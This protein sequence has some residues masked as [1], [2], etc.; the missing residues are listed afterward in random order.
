MMALREPSAG[1]PSLR[2]DY[3]FK[4]LPGAVFLARPPPFYTRGVRLTRAFLE[5]ENRC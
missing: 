2:H 4:T 1:L 5:F 3:F